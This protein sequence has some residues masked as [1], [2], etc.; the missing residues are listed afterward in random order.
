MGPSTAPRRTV[1]GNASGTTTA[2][3]R[4]SSQQ[5]GKKRDSRAGMRKVTSLT[6]EQLERKRAND[7]EAQ[8][9]IRARTKEHIE[10]L[11][12]QVAELSAKGQQVDRVLERN[13]ALESEI[14]HLRQQLAMMTNSRQL[15]QSEDDRRSSTSSNPPS[16]IS[17]PFNSPPLTDSI[18]PGPPMP[19]LTHR[20][21]L[22]QGSWHSYVSPS[23]TGALPPTSISVSGAEQ[24]H[25]PP[26]P[27][28][29]DPLAGSSMGQ[30]HH[31][32]GYGLPQTT[33]GAQYS[34]SNADSYNRNLTYPSRAVLGQPQQQ[35]QH[36][37][38][39]IPV[40]TMGYEQNI[41]SLQA[42][43]LPVPPHQQHHTY[44]SQILHS[45]PAQSQMGYQ[46][47]SRG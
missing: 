15:Y 47:D 3:G 31:D 41:P 35:Q 32:M 16:V 2:T 11:E 21:S 30:A 9:T 45:P 1:A 33:T 10:N 36:R 26:Y 40:A 17:S 28:T 34:N 42:A 44:P 37:P 43:H 24:S 39:H 38:Q 4:E 6:A 46:W 8:R 29:A 20:M 18:A 19:P 27:M 12:H 22:P 14:A 23:Q 13:A 25:E 5:T 7:R